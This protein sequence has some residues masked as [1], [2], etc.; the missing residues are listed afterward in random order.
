MEL[1]LDVTEHN[2]YAVLAVFGEV[3]LTGAVTMRVE[4]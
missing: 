3:T 4:Q 2:G 1:G